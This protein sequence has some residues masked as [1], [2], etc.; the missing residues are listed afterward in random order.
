MLAR[1]F[2]VTQEQIDALCD[3]GEAEFTPAEGAA[4]RFAEEMTFDPA[5][6]PD[7]TFG[8]LRKHWDER[9]I[10]E[11]TAVAGLFNYFNRFNNALETDLTKYPKK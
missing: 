11:I 6:V 5:K 1:R 9:Q 3:K 7:E 4:I 10:V 2:G 8:E